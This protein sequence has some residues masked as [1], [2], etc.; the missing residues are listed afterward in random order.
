[1]RVDSQEGAELIALA[2]ELDVKLT[3]DSAASLL[4]LVDEL[5][6]WSRA[7]NLTSIRER[8]EIVTR[9]ILDSLAIHADLRGSTVADIGTGAGFPG[10]P[11]AIASPERR[12]TLIDSNGKKV[13]F[14]EHAVRE[15][16]LGNVRVVQARAEDMHPEV[17]FDTVVARAFAPLPELLAK[18]RGLAGP[19]TRLLAMKGRFP[20]E[21]L[22]AV[23]PPWRAVGIRP[24]A[25]PGLAEAR[26]L[27]WL[28]RS[29][30]YPK[31]R[32]GPIL[33]DP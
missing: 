10:L 28:E 27:V 20:R 21:E 7:Y 2:R 24:L 22:A 16:D 15:L 13:R 32:V 5:S 23:G 25:V 14:V 4:R 12:F 30:P 19:E 9:H 17:P 11:L 29:D 3:E 33:P 6:R 31:S 8:S 1:M 26:H 18:V